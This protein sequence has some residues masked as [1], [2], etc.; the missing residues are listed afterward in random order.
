MHQSEKGRIAPKLNCS[1][2]TRGLKWFLWSGNKQKRLLLKATSCFCGN[3]WNLKGPKVAPV[4]FW[5]NIEVWALCQNLVLI[6]FIFLLCLQQISISLM[7]KLDTTHLWQWVTPK[8]NWASLLKE[9]V[10][11][12]V[13]ACQHI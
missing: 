4:S 13:S 12:L 10:S 11:K 5:S 8:A 9:H 2:V 7:I 1:N 3:N 6:P